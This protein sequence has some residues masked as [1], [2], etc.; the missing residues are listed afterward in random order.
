MQNIQGLDGAKSLSDLAGA[1][2]S[3]V[4]TFLGYSVIP[5]VLPESQLTDRPFYNT[6]NRLKQGN[7]INGVPVLQSVSFRTANGMTQVGALILHHVQS[8]C[9]VLLC[10]PFLN[11]NVELVSEDIS[12]KPLLCLA[13][14][15]P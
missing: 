5:Q 7:S 2:P 3:T 10:M 15:M 4:S 1:I 14:I 13:A 6:T 8:C 12:Y 11:Q 9:P